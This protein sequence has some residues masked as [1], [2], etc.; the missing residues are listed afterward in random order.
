[1]IT[2]DNTTIFICNFKPEFNNPLNLSNKC[3]KVL[4]TCELNTNPGLDVIT[5]NP[6]LNNNLWCEWS[7]IKWILDNCESEYIGVCSY[8]R[9]FDFKDDLSVLKDKNYV[10]TPPDGNPNNSLAFGYF[11]SIKDLTD[12]V[13]YYNYL[14]SE[15]DLMKQILTQFL[16]CDFCYTNNMVILPNKIFKD[17]MKKIFNILFKYFAYRGFKTEEDVKEHI[18]DKTYDFIKTFSPNDTVEYQIRYF[19]YYAERIF[20]MFLTY[21]LKDFPDSEL[22]ISTKVISEKK[23]GDYL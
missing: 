10:I 3:Y 8:R 17:I 23:Y 11:H 14:Y 12:F 20:S 15:N 2:E 19:A 16:N 18:L 1:M 4:S 6:E 7:H 9:Y 22:Y 5:F 13:F 21:N